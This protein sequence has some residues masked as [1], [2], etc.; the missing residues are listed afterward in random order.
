MRWRRALQWPLTPS[1]FPSHPSSGP[2]PSH[3]HHQAMYQ[4]DAVSLE[5]RLNHSDAEHLALETQ[6]RAQA[7]AAADVS[8][9]TRSHCADL[10]QALV[11]VRAR[12]TESEEMLG[13]AKQDIVTLRSRLQNIQ[14]LEE[15]RRDVESAI[16][17]AASQQQQ[18]QQQARV[19]S[20]AVLVLPLCLSLRC[21]RPKLSKSAYVQCGAVQCRPCAVC[22]VWAP[23]VSCCCCCCC[24]WYGGGGCSDGSSLIW[25]TAEGGVHCRGRGLPVAIR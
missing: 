21:G 25:C 13:A 11:R 1:P 16:A 20:V 4:T 10:E 8:A 22:T 18:Q 2:S 7:S 19:R 3:L 17:S 24:C 9:A 5:S 23:R 12:A 14:T 6:L 15:S